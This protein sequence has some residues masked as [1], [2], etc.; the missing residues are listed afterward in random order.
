MAPNRPTA[1]TYLPGGHFPEE[2]Y[3]HTVWLADDDTEATILIAPLW[4]VQIHR[5]PL[6]LQRLRLLIC[7][8][9][10][11]TPVFTVPMSP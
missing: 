8:G 2:S 4:Y 5:A 10:E 3:L 7:T 6:N 9:G 1:R 11:C